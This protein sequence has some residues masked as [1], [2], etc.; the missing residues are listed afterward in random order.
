MLLRAMQ[1]YMDKVPEYAGIILVSDPLE[2][3]VCQ[4]GSQH[5]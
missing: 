3:D 5:S 2:I 4:V 1:T